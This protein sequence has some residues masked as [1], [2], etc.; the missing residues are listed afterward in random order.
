LD[1]RAAFASIRA[2]TLAIDSALA[3]RHAVRELV[4]RSRAEAV[5]V[6]LPLSSPAAAAVGESLEAAGLGFTGIGPHFSPS[7]DVLKLAYLVEP[8]AREPIKTFEPFAARLT[9]YA[10]AEQQRVR[11]SL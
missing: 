3:I 8:L 4:E 11:E 7:G 5:I 6:E 10:L 9:D 2:Q 1:Q